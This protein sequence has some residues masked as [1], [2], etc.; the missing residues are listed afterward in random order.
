MKKIAILLVTAVIAGMAFVSCC[1]SK[2]AEPSTSIQSATIE[3]GKV[4]TTPNAH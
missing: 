2:A 4:D 1:S 3:N